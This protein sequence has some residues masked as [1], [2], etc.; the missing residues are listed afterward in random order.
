MRTIGKKDYLDRNQV[1]CVVRVYNLLSD[2]I[3]IRFYIDP[4]RFR[5]GRLRFRTNDGW[6]VKAT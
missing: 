3:G 5:K 6:K 4:W 2:E 1:Y